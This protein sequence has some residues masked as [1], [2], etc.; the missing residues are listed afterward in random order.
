MYII[1][2]D[3]LATKWTIS[4]AKKEER[5]NG[6]G[7]NRSDLVKEG[8]KTSDTKRILFREE[9]MAIQ[10]ANMLNLVLI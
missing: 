3:V 9:E 1:L 7:G 10:K 4:F 5:Q 8:L 2:M 6:L